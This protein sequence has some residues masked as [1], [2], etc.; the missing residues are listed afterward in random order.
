MANAEGYYDDGFAYGDQSGAH[1][2][3][4]TGSSMPYGGGKRKAQDDDN[5]L[6]YAP[7]AKKD[8]ALQASSAVNVGGGGGYTGA[9]RG[10]GDEVKSPAAAQQAGATM[11]APL[12]QCGEPAQGVTSKVPQQLTMSAPAALCICM[13]QQHRA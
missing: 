12:C 6:P 5:G 1:D 13:T 9:A 3:S 4:Y 11:P 2:I 8:T 10:W 7:A